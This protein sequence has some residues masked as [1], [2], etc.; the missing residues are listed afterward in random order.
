[1]R[2]LGSAV[3]PEVGSPDPS[4]QVPSPPHVRTDP[5]AFSAM[6]Y[7]PPAATAITPEPAPAG[8]FVW[9]NPFPPH[10]ITEPSD[11]SA[12]AWLRP[13]ATAA[14]PEDA[15][16]GRVV[17]PFPFLPQATTA[18]FFTA[19]IAKLP[20]LTDVTPEP[21]ALTDAGTLSRLYES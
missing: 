2:P 10:A 15:D 4:E 7:M 17:S 20:A 9:P 14:T 3:T 8:T 16:A 21:G 1:M 11:F 18:P 13:P 6:L 19:Y 5:S 12:S